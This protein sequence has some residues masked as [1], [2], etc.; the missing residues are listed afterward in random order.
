ML[1]V[2]VSPRARLTFSIFAADSDIGDSEG[3]GT[4]WAHTYD[5]EVPLG[6]SDSAV[7]RTGRQVLG[8]NAGADKSLLGSRVGDRTVDRRGRHLGPYGWGGEGKESQYQETK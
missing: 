6:V 3:V 8:D 4:T 7:G 2:S 5:A 1:K